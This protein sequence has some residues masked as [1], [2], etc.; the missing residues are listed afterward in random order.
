MAIAKRFKQELK[1][2]LSAKK[3]A[4]DE[5]WPYALVEVRQYITSN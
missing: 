2:V 1:Y 4:V 3:L 5:R